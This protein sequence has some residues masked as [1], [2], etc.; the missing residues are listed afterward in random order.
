MK[1]KVL[2]SAFVTVLLF[3]INSSYVKADS[4][5]T[6]FHNVEKQDNIVSTTYFKGDG[7]NENLIPFKKKVDV[8]NE[9][10]E[11]V[12]KITYVWDPVVLDW[13]PSAKMKYTYSNSSVVSVERSVWD[14]RRNDWGKTQRV[15]Y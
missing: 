14:Q 12:S 13:A 4:D 2:L 5:A 11:C 10:G 9:K 3:A 1:V 6:L 8:L 7:N 15:D